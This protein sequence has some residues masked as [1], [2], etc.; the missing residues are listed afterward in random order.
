[1]ERLA[2]AFA[3]VESHVERWYNYL[4]LLFSPP[5]RHRNGDERRRNPREC[6]LCHG[7][8]Q[9]DRRPP[10]DVRKPD[11]QIRRLPEEILEWFKCG[12]CHGTQVGIR[13]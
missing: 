11:G 9:R 6:T 13:P 1:M 12:R 2:Y 3:V 8:M 7:P 10:R 4:R 5:P